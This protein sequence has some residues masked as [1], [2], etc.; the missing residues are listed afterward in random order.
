MVEKKALNAEELDQKLRELA[1]EWKKDVNEKGVPFIYRVHHA[2]AF[3]DGIDFVRKVAEAA[4]EN[5]HHPD[6]LIHYKRI[7]IRYWT[8][9]ASGVTLADVQMAQKIDPLF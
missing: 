4:E 2:R 7:T 3:M 8:H 9:T 6:I 5:N 1:P